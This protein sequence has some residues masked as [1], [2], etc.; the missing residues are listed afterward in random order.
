MPSLQV[1]QDTSAITGAL[2]V[3]TT[4]LVALV[5]VLAHASCRRQDARI[6][7]SLLLHPRG[8]SHVT[9]SC[10]ADRCG[11]I[12]R[13]RSER[14]CSVCGRCIANRSDDRPGAG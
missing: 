6:T 4:T 8:W 5:S 7:L 2:Y 9:C 1:F 14:L 13:P 12:P 10:T 11:D 3:A